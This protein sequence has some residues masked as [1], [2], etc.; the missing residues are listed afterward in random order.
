MKVKAIMKTNMLEK[1]PRLDHKMN[2]RSEKRI[3]KQEDGIQKMETSAFSYL[4]H[5]HTAG[6]SEIL[7]GKVQD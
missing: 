3:G 6:S 2:V 4:R 7:E 5:I 1:M